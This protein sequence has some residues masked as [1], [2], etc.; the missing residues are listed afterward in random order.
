MSEEN[1]LVRK[2]TIEKAFTTGDGIENAINEVSDIVRGYEHDLSTVSGRKKT[3]S[4]SAKVSKTKVIIDNIG[5]DLVSEWK[6]KAKIV[7]GNRKKLRDSFDE[8]RDEARKPLKDWE[9]E[10]A[11][12]EAKKLAAE[13]AEKLAALIE[14]DHEIAILLNDKFDDDAEAEIIMAAQREEAR[15]AE[16]RERIAEEERVKA[17]RESK[18]AAA[19]AEQ[20]AQA[21]KEAE[22]RA[23]EQAAEA[24]RQREAAEKQAELDKKLAEERRIEAARI[25]KEQ[26]EKAAEQARLDE[27][28]RQQEEQ[29]RIKAEEEKREANK[30]HVGGVR[31]KAKEALMTLGVDEKTAKSIVMAIHDGKIP[32]VSIKY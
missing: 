21:A 2:E 1:S 12:I 31:R 11:A 29:A 4:L 28:K 18:E 19:K 25:A 16:L 13:E 8:L 26:A 30:R 17:Q 23:I 14:S 7:D 20:E 3:A 27:V 22:Q 24:V 10:Q 5:K 6:R 32:H 9:D 15:Q